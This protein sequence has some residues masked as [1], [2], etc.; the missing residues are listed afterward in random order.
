M[1]KILLVIITLVSVFML[2]ACWPAEVGVETTFNADGSGTRVFV[3][4]IMDDTLSQT[5]I[6]NP[7]DPEQDEDKG[8]VVND[9]H[10]KGGLSKIQDW[11]EANAP[12]FMTV[13]P[14]TTDGVH[15]YFKMSF[16]FT[17]FEDFLAKYK[18]LVN[19]SPSISWD[20]FDETELPTFKVEGSGSMKDITFTE[21]KV[22]V[23]A[24]LDWAVE[25]IYKDLYDAQDLAGY[26]T[27]VDI[28]VLANVKI[29]VGDGKFEEL[30]HYDPNGVE[31]DGKTGKVIFVESESF[32]AKG[33]GEI[34]SGMSTLAVVGITAGSILV[35]GGVLA[36]FMLK[37]RS[38]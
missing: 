22:L 36:F 30:R 23:E 10:I 7:D 6:I 25:G 1:K 16:D 38:V 3:I 14:M 4:D 24:S 15:R 2:T 33:K 9:K 27:K 19:L 31:A 29:Q 8:P 17:S 13:H 12:D 11:L 32:T 35:V 18:Q 34:K 21:S 5:P 26:V 28:W 37:K 20:D